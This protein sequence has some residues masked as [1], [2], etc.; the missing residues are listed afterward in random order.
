MPKIAPPY[1]V[2][3]GTRP[4]RPGQAFSS[5]RAV[6]AD[7]RARHP[8][9]KQVVPEGAQR[10]PLPSSAGSGPMSLVGRA[11]AETQLQRTHHQEGP[12]RRRTALWNSSP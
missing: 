5:V 2:V 1:R 7:R 6:E 9:G 11:C 8:R 4:S 3:H 12:P 10:F